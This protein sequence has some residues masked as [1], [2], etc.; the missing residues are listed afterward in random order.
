MR[1]RGSLAQ[2]ASASI[3]AGER[4]LAGLRLVAAA[5]NGEQA[6]AHELQH[7]AA[8]A[9]D[10]VDQDLGMVVQQA[11]DLGVAGEQLQH[12]GAGDLVGQAGEAGEVAVPD[13]GMDHLHLAALDVAAEHPPGGVRTEIGREQRARGRRAQR[14]GDHHGQQ[15]LDAP[16]A[17]DVGLARSRPA[18]R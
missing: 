11:Q 18:G 9:L 5:E 13:H 17:L 14:G 3:Q 6:V 10:R 16:D 15:R 8:L 4:R 1:R 12:A 7:L 2:R